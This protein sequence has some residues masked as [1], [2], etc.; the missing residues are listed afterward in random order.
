MLMGECVGKEWSKAGTRVLSRH[1]PRADTP[2]HKGNARMSQDLESSLNAQYGPSN[3]GDRI[4]QAMVGA[5]KDVGTLSREDLEGC[6]EFHIGGR[7]ATRML[8][9]IA[10][11]GKGTKV[12]D[13]GSG[14]GGAAR[15]LASEFGATVTGVEISTSYHEA[16]QVLTEKVG[17][18]GVT[19]INGNALALPI[20]DASV[21]V[22]WLQ[23]VQMNIEDKAAL[24]KSIRRVLKPGGRLAWHGIVRG[25][26]PQG[27]RYPVPWADSAELSH[28]VGVDAL[29]AHF[30][31]A[32]LQLMDDSW[33]DMNAAAMDFFAQAK[34]KSAA[35]APEQRLGLNLLMGDSTM[36]K[37]PNLKA[38]IKSERVSVYM[39]V[40]E[41]Q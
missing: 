20:E 31:D 17:V 15:T 25:T 18:E 10:K 8:A 34:A 37:L 3:L 28:L 2:K 36:Q 30:A 5:G 39:G 27:V 33:R 12:L 21:D 40:F 9:E 6:S 11:I 16:A 26:N 4:L 23:H 14:L 35:L 29:K 41:A 32:G 13:I 1:Q 22:V 7:P 38:N 24:A 19:H